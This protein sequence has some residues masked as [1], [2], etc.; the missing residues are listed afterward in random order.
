MKLNRVQSEYIRPH[1]LNSATKTSIMKSKKPS[2]KV[3][4]EPNKITIKKTGEF[5]I[6]EDYFDQRTSNRNNKNILFKEEPKEFNTHSATKKS[7]K[8]SK[9]LNTP[10]SIP[11]G[12]TY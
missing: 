12:S 2:D 6:P 7:L 4:I 11:Q 5:L 8:T 10:N 1:S 9:L 3:S